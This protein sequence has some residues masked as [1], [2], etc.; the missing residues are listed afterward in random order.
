MKARRL[1]DGA[2]FGPE[3]LKAIG[4]AFDLAW[5]EIAGNFGGD[6][7]DVERARLRLAEAMLSIATEDS[8]DVE[9]LKNGALQAMALGYRKPRKHR[10]NY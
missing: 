2:S 4:E 3:I 10:I 5:A 8:R 1:I 9:A 7:F 6:P